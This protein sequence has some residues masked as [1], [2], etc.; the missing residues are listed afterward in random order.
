MQQ[1]KVRLTAQDLMRERAV[2]AF[3]HDETLTHL[4][5]VEPRP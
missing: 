4:V 2:S 5:S 1:H 3:A